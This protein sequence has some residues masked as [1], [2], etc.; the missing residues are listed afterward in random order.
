M[1]S[2]RTGVS[3]TIIKR[4][5]K[6]AQPTDTEYSTLTLACAY[7]AGGVKSS[8]SHKLANKVVGNRK[9]TSAILKHLTNLEGVR[10]LIANEEDEDVASFLKTVFF[11]A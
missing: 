8:I 11:G 9:A 5:I 6:T 3:K 7:V 1:L 10:I 4:L 2:N